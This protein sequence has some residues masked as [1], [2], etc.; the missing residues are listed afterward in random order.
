[1]VIVANDLRK[2]LG[3]GALARLALENAKESKIII[4]GIRNPAE[5]DE[6]KKSNAIIIAVDAPLQTRF[7]RLISRNRS[8]DP[9]NWQDFIEM[10]RRDKGIN[11]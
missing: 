3:N 8:S 11:Q 4:D 10:D 1:M 5:V 2:K 6:L 9:K 7:S